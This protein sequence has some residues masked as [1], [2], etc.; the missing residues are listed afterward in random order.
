[1]KR[2]LMFRDQNDKQEASWGGAGHPGWGGAPGEVLLVEE[3]RLGSLQFTQLFNEHRN[4]G[5][6]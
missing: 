4:T 6:G 3:T 5:E 2:P 1:M